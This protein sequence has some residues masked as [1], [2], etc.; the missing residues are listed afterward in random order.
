[1]LAMARHV[2][3]VKTWQCV[4]IVIFL[5]AVTF[6]ASSGLVAFVYRNLCVAAVFLNK[7]LFICLSVL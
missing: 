7:I 3:T 6:F 4:Q 2:N 1:M 5:S